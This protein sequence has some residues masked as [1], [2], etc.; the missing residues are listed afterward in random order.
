ML[1]IRHSLREEKKKSGNTTIAKLWG[2]R[3]PRKNPKTC[4][5][6]RYQFNKA[7]SFNGD[8]VCHVEKKSENL[9]DNLASNKDGSS[10]CQ[11]IK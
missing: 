5:L 6:S 9:C 4:S 8:N 7:F 10:S 11:R 3:K 2:I 1:R